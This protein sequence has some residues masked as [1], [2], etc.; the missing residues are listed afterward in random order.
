MSSQ[1]RRLLHAALTI[2]LVIGSVVDVCAGW[3]AGFD[4][5]SEPGE[6]PRRARASIEFVSERDGGGV[7]FEEALGQVVADGHLGKLEHVFLPRID[8]K[9][10]KAFEAEIG[11][12]LEKTA[13][14][15]LDAA[16]R[17]YPPLTGGMNTTSSS[18]AR[19][20]SNVA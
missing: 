6:R 16:R 5:G 19:T 10:S 12:V 20:V 11:A 7:T 9:E 15:Q 13:P 3:R 14:R 2:T 18:D 1:Y 8:D 17:S 4:P